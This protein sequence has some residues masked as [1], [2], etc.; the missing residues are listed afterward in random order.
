[1]ITCYPIHPSVTVCRS[2]NAKGHHRKMSDVQEDSCIICK[3]GFD[4]QQ[5]VT[6]SK[7]G[8]LTLVS[9]REN[10]AVQISKAIQLNVL[11]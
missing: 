5:F 11:A 3:Q 2:C 8:I 10:V 7:K 9:Y 1:M 4:E 6:V